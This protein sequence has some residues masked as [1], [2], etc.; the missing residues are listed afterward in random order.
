MRTLA[1][2]I[3]TS[4]GGVALLNG[5]ELV[6]NETFSAG[7]EHGARFFAVLERALAVRQPDQIVVGLGPGSYSGTRIAI[8]AAVGLSLG[9]GA[10]LLG[11]PSIAAFAA[12]EFVAIG[13]ARRDSFYF[14]HV[15][16][17]EVLEGPRLLD[18]AALAARLG[19]ND[20]PI[21]AAEPLDFPRVTLRF[22]MAEKLARLAVAGIS[23]AARG[24]LE[25]IYLRDPHITIPRPVS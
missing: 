2:E 5:S 21:F 24:Q 7:R 13:D 20:F 22:P 4:Q 17:G 6:F 18:R 12:D 14:S 10:K 9:T 19:K 8:S 25:P 15:R 1:L 23:I 16:N 3:S 11:I